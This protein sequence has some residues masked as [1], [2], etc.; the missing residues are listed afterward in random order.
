MLRWTRGLSVLMVAAAAAWPST[1]LDDDEAAVAV[2]SAVTPVS[3]LAV[4]TPRPDPLAGLDAYVESAMRSWD[5]PGVALVVVRGD[6]VLGRGY[7]VTAAGGD[8]VAEHTLFGIGSLTKAFTATVLATLV[9]EGALSW[10]DPVSKHL[11]DF[12]MRDP[13]VTRHL[14]VRD[15]LSHRTGLGGNDLVWAAAAREP[16][17]LIR[18][19]QFQEPVFGFRAAFGYSN[20]MYL[21][22]GE[23]AAAVAGKPWGALVRERIFEPLGMDRSTTDLAELHRR[24]N[25]ALPHD[26]IGAGQSLGTVPS[27]KLPL[28][29]PTTVRRI[30][31]PESAVAPAGG[32]ASSAAEFGRWLRF[33]LGAGAVDGKRLVSEEALIATR[34]PQIPSPGFPRSQSEAS[35]TNLAAYG[36]GWGVRDYRGRLMVSHL[37]STP[38]WGGVAMLLPTE[39]LA[40]AVFAN[41]G[42]GLWLADAVARWTLD[43]LVGA[44]PKDWNREALGWAGQ[45]RQASVDALERAAAERVAGTAPSLPLEAYAGVYV[46]SL[47][48]DARITHRQGRLRLV[49]GPALAGDLDH[50]QD[51]VFRVTWD[52]PVFGA[53]LV[54]F[55]V[56][57]GE[58]PEV[59]HTR[60]LGRE[61]IWRRRDEPPG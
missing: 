28:D 38:G 40:V 20:P 24:T 46:D 45:R 36:M 58:H 57:S 8:P 25:V 44:E 61:A 39:D 55:Q 17:E 37:G 27:A 22:A 6:S 5:A 9:D 34:T 2:A 15:A 52:N 30:G 42:Q 32:I 16:A 7:G 13:Y 50:W 43:R 1:G 10:D 48:P 56:A 51:D 31:W 23:L 3:G 19:L 29:A 35:E 21:V 12:R 47:Y 4:Q 26:E 60:V 11:P 54:T 33:Q 41:I 18:A 59:L 53:N 49:L 14:T